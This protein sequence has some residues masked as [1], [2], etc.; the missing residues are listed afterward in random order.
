M[1]IIIFQLKLLDKIFTENG[2]NCFMKI[3]VEG[4]EKEV[5]LAQKTF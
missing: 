4:H 2:K 1:V 5:I 3:D